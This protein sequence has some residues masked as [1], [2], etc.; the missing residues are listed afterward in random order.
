MVGAAA[1]VIRAFLGLSRKM[2]QFK[3]D[4]EGSPARRGFAPVPGVPER[5]KKVEDAIVEIG[6]QFKPNG[7]STARD[8]INRMELNQHRQAIDQGILVRRMDIFQE[9]MA[10]VIAELIEW[11]RAHNTLSVEP[12]EPPPLPDGEDEL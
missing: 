8:A 2:D 7:G 5:L 1:A 6:A 12:T 10:P 9:Q 3:E 11:R 4:W